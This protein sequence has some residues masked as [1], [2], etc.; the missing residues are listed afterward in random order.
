M[1]NKLL[2]LLCLAFAANLVAGSVSAADPNL[3]GW[4]K[5][6][7]TSG[8]TAA[9]SSGY[10]ND[11]TLSGYLGGDEWTTGIDG[12]ALRFNWD[13]YINCGTASS[14]DIATDFTVCAWAKPAP[15]SESSYMG[16]GGRLV[17]SPSY[18][19]FSLVRHSSGVYRLW[20]ANQAT[21]AVVGASSTAT[22]TASEWHH[23]A[24][25]RTGAT[26]SLYVDG[27][28][29]GTANV[30]VMVP[31]TNIFHIGNQYANT[32]NDR[33]WIG[34]MDDFRLYNR[35]L[36]DA[37]VA[38]LGTATK[39]L[40]P[41]PV[42]G[43]ADWV[44]PLL[45]WKG[46]A[47]AQMHNVYLGTTP[48]LTQ[49]DFKMANP[50]AMP[51][52]PA[53][54]LTPG[55]TYYW[56]VDEVA[57]DG[58]ISK[59]DVWSFTVMPL[60]AHFPSPSDGAV[61]R[62]AGTKL[63]WTAGQNAMS[64]TVYFGADRAAVAAGDASVAKGALEAKTFDPGG[65]AGATTYYWRVDESDAAG[66]V[67]AGDV[68]SFS[69]F[70]PNGGAVAEYWDNMTFTGEPKVVKI[71]PEINFD[72]GSAATP[73]TNSP[74]PCIP[75]DKFS[76]RWTAELNVPVTG[77]YILY[78]ASD[79]GA[80]MWLNGQ[81]VASGWW[82]RGTTEDRTLKLDLVAGERYQ[83]VME[84]YENGGGATAFLRWSGPGIPKEIIPQGALMPPQGAFSL[85]PANG[86]TG[87]ADTPVLSWRVGEKALLQTVYLSADKAKVAASDPTVAIGSIP[88]PETSLT[89]TA[90]FDRGVTRFWKVDVITADGTTVPSLISSFRM[91]DKNTEN[92]AVGIGAAEPNYLATFVQNGTY[93]IGTFGGDQTYEFIVRS[94]PAETM[95]SMCL[96]GRLNFGDTKAGLKYEQ[97]ENTGHYGATVFGVMDY[98]YG[99]DTA[100]GEYT[101]LVFVANKAAGTTEL[102]V[103]GALK[104]S[105]PAAISLS[106][107]V[108][109]GRAIRANGTF[110]DNFDGDIFGVAI[111]GRALSADEIAKHADMYF[112]PIEI[113][114]PDLLIYY[115][116]ES[117][118]GTTAIDQ[119]GHSN[120]GLL[121]GNPEWTT[122]PFGGCLSLDMARMDS[123][124][125]APLGIVSNHVTVSG[126]VK[127]DQTPA[128]WSGILTTRGSG[129]LGLQ[130]NGSEGPLGPE[131]RYMW[132]ADQYWDFS[133]GLVVPNGEWYFAALTISPTQGKLYL[134]GPD[135][136]ATNVAEHVPV[137]FDGV[138][139]IGRD[140]DN[141]RLMTCLIDE[142]RFYNRTLTDV[143][144]QRLILT[145]VTGPGDVVQGVPN[146]G[147][148][149][150]AEYPDLA[151]DDNV[152]TKF[153]HFKG[154]TQ[155]TGIQVTPAVGST[156]VTGLTFTTANDTPGRD[157]IKFELSG[158]NDS[159]D[160]P[161]TL[162][163]AGDIVDFAQATE[164][165]RFSMNAT[166]VSFENAVAYTHY[167][168][169]FPSVRPN[170]DGLM[171]IAEIEF[172]GSLQ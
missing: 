109:I 117:G 167:Q 9:D 83:L 75:V 25:V 80:R 128:A 74:D 30:P 56:R 38:A 150:P 155:P 21:A 46:A 72:W 87:L 99:V 91:A 36:T 132:G 145:D 157:P 133:S 124:Q 42:D 141:A 55:T 81:Q 138:I 53:G 149:P 23:V 162:I 111:Y 14:L 41:S 50:A 67:Q 108:G 148:W 28:K 51:L 2:G 158:S 122:G 16:I 156:V 96:I 171:Q 79:D 98:D 166:A 65:L 78:E 76:C 24:G 146:D 147:D 18:M 86:A 84:M 103:N 130:H 7:E 100:P 119:S 58:A 129:N 57:A 59:G 134:N 107:Q 101:H 40:S 27:V 126:W 89:P 32:T 15:G 37:E 35:G 143:G 144:I 94:N 169:T 168:I 170:T 71:V 45:Q 69:T 165:P 152:N 1:R 19:G 172:L 85:S 44:T 63:G 113:T 54:L 151:I 4:W 64:H 154:G 163:A 5:L 137:T 135:Q 31:S 3:V 104:G 110:V 48:E 13:G 52:F 82:D 66:T 47:N 49:A 115:D 61:W 93:D 127:H 139:R 114:D 159:I 95:T 136:T 73:G 6:D 142:V 17:S 33:L 62:P 112:N 131:L 29:A 121:M 92:W 26:C 123:I 20:V 118:S 160:G 120:H 125:A 22:Y 88:L 60:K 11:G 70:D 161:W 43:A 8:M 39:A 97:W 12:G 106:G 34:L 10:G 90:A 102:Y 105:V 153:L 140:T 116:F 77:K 68:W 164:W